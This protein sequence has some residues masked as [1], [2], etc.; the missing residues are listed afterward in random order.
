MEV[1]AYPCARSPQ[2][3][4]FCFQ[5]VNSEL[6]F[7]FSYWEF[8]IREPFILKIDT[9]FLLGCEKHSTPKSDYSKENGIGDSTIQ[10]GNKKLQPDSSA[11]SR[12]HVQASGGKG[13]GMYLHP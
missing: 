3:A 1:F 7:E 13:P 12:S 8:Q 6:H 11:F 9:F 10:R 4:G 5:I 2:L